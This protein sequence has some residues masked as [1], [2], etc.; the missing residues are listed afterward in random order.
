MARR[1]GTLFDRYVVVDWSANARPKTGRDSIWVAEAGRSGPPTV[2]NPSTRRAAER[3]LAEVVASDGR[4]L[5]AVDA[6]LGYPSGTAEWFGFEGGAAWRAMWQHLERR[7]A[8]DDRNGNDRFAV[9]AELNRR[10]EAALFWGRPARQHHD[11]LDTR[12]PTRFPVAEFRRIES[13]LRAERLRPASVWQLLGVGSVGSQTLTLLPVLERLFRNG[14]VEIWPF[15][16]GLV[17]PA[18]PAGT[19]VVAEI[20]PTAFDV[21]PTLHAVRDAAQ[22]MSVADR[23]RRADRGGRLAAWLAPTVDD[24][25]RRAAESEEGWLLRPG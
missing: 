19:T 22:V 2:H 18:V 8:D 11:G 5:L 23:L 6:S 21:D 9:A 15:T 25:D 14:R 4:T 13:S 17:T 3:S 16:T 24:A 10:R 12:K 7:L 20:W 1:A